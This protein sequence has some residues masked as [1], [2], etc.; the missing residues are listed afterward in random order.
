MTQGVK[1]EGKER[2]RRV[3]CSWLDKKQDPFGLWGEKPLTRK[4]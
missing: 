1:K 3:N 2:E 4:R